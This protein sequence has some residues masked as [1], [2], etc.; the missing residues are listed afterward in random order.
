MLP[1]DSA[2]PK[3]NAVF[4]V[5]STVSGLF[6]AARLY[7]KRL[8]G[9]AYWWDDLLLLASWVSLSTRCLACLML[10]TGNQVV[11]LVAICIISYCVSLGLGKHTWDVDPRNFVLL[12][13]ASN[14][15][16]TLSIIASIWSKTSFAL[17]VLRL[18]DG[19]LRRLVWFLIASINVAM[20]V[21]A[22]LAW[23]H[24][25]PLEK[26]WDSQAEG[27]CWPREI[28]Q[29]YNFFSAGSC[30]ASSLCKVH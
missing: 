17:T 7:A 12:L 24:C 26:L 3:L 9:R 11:N 4:W 22:L 29:Y 19:W 2:G 27:T 18:A 1:H 13:R 15:T 14:V 16:A 23:I 30:I 6:M 8:R 28:V 10:I 20:G 5:R 21:T 25:T